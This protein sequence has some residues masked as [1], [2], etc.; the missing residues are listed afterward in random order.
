MAIWQTNGTGTAVSPV[1]GNTY[2]CVSNGIAIG[3]DLNETL[4]RSPAVG[5]LSTFPG[6]S[7]TLDT[8]TEIRLK[9]VG[10]TLNFP[11]VGGN[12]G[13][14][15]KGGMLNVG[16]SG[17]FTV[18]G[19]V[20]AFTGTKSYLCPGND[21]AGSVDA[22]RYID[23]TGQLTGSG[24]LVLFEGG[25]SN[26]MQISCSSNTFSGQWIVKC[27]WLQGAGINSLGT[28]SIT[29]DPDYALASPP[30]DP[31]ITNAQAGPA[32]FEVNYDLEQRGRADLDER[33]ADAASPELRFQRG[34][35][36][37]DFVERRAPTL[38]RRL[39]AAYPANF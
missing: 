18:T 7:L 1:S 8:N 38:T 33:W 29:V 28:D 23:F 31:S 39:T 17:G 27:G 14:I 11:G 5:G 21:D 3:N 25:T 4:I 16:D 19:M 37:R 30:F 24:N 32:V 12:P 34:D 35:N 6:N 15:L 10:S 26:P 9:T 22:N 20:Q 36:R 13:L 2:E